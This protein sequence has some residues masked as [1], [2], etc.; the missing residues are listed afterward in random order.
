MIADIKLNLVR[1]KIMFRHILR[2]GNQLADYL[3][4]LAI[5]KDNYSF[6]YFN[7]METTGTELINSDRLNCCTSEVSPIQG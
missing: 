3:V 4:N 6:L 7:N 2:K 1:K 5:D